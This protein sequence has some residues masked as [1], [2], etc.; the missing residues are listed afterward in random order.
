MSTAPP[1]DPTSTPPEWVLWQWLDSAF[2]AG[3]FAHSGG[4]EAAWQAGEVPGGEAL[5]QFLRVS[6]RQAEHGAVPFAIAAFDDPPDFHAIDA[7]CDIFLNNHVAN[8]GSRRRGQALLR[9]AAEVF[10]APAL[11][12]VLTRVM[13]GESPGHFAPAFGLASGTIGLPRQSVATALLYTTLRDGVWSG[14]RLGIVGPL[15]GQRI[16]RELAESLAAAPMTP[17]LH[18]KDAVQTSPL[19]ELLQGT[20][21][22]LYSRLFQT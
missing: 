14:V 7:R 1:P 9:S 12:P 6:V 18:Y 13:R 22:R 17:P 15:E 20:H 16:Q 2:P 8:R 4:L 10:D 5:K 19:L 11:A 21:D 3:G